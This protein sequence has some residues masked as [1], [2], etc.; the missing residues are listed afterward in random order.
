MFNNRYEY[1]LNIKVDIQYL[2][3]NAGTILRCAKIFSLFFI[4]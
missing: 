4:E 3:I 2:F 1:I